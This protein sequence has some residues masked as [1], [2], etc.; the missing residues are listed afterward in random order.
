MSSAEFLPTPI[1]PSQ[2]ALATPSVGANVGPN[3]VETLHAKVRTGTI[4]WVW[5]VIMNFIRFPLILLG[6]FI[7]LGYFNAVGRPHAFGSALMMTNVTITLT[8]DLGCFLL[9][10]WLTRKEGIRLRDLIGFERKRLF[11]DILLG[12]GL[13]LL[14][15][16]LFVVIANIIAPLLVYGPDIFR[17]SQS[18]TAP[19]NANPFELP[20]WYFWWGV[21]VLPLGVGIM[22]EM[23]YR[24]Y[25][26]P[27]FIALTNKP[28]V[29]ILL[30]SLGFGVQHIA[31]AL[32]SW[33]AALTRFLGMFLLA[34]VF[35]LLYLKL[36][37]LMPLIIAHWLLDLVGLGL[38]SLMAVLA[39]NAAH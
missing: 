5:P 32:T 1:V 14:L 29:A 3:S 8:A 37:R 9:L 25:V 16:V 22:E 4:T 30:M 39:T 13:F 23:T 20:L 26:L 11:M 19:F 12:L 36:K 38:F 31:F 33:Q 17:A 18:T 6:F 15:I 35:A 10:V 28:W 24:A 7:T 21:L 27:R 2:E 34:P